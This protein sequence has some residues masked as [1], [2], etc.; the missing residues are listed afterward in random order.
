MGILGGLTNIIM[1]IEDYYCYS[2]FVLVLSLY[3]HL[4]KLNM[5]LEGGR[6]GRLLLQ[7]N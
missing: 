4:T 5:S 7:H 1:S 3:G 6:G 2:L